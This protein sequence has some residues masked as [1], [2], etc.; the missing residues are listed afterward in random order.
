MDNEKIERLRERMLQCA[1]CMDEYRDPRILPCHHTLCFD[2]VFNVVNSS[3][4][5][6][7]LFKC[8]QCRSDVFVPP[9]GIGDLPINFYI[10]SLQDELG[11]KGYTAPCFICDRDWL[12]AQF[13][14]MDCDIDICRFCIHAH[15]LKTHRDIPKIIRI[16]TSPSNTQQASIIMCDDHADELMQMFCTKCSKSICITCSVSTHKHH[17]I[18]PLNTKLKE[19]KSFLQMQVDT[20]TLEKR[21]AVKTAECL[22]TAKNEALITFNRSRLALDAVHNKACE[23]IRKKRFE[24]EMELRDSKDKQV[25]CIDKAL[26]DFTVYTKEID[27]GLAFL[28]DL[29][30]EDMC[31][32]VLDSYKE[33]SHQLDAVRRDVTSNHVRVDQSKFSPKRTSQIFDFNFGVFRSLYHFGNLG[34]LYTREFCLSV[35][36]KTLELSKHH[37]GLS[38]I[39]SS[40]PVRYF[41]QFMLSFLFW[42]FIFFLCD[43]TGIFNLVAGV[44]LAISTFSWE[45]VYV[46]V[47]HIQNLF[48]I[49]SSYF[50]NSVTTS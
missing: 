28:L 19:S 22:K 50:L 21:K 11:A 37:Q 15:R 45:F 31:L 41:I 2:C 6:G 18:I 27:R 13:R 7:R 35:H 4:A 39:I 49:C 12:A 14:C 30:D 44:I 25:K 47:Q 17:T 16:E 29:L 40:R 43:F 10:T 38:Y 42:Q 9:G 1:V 48:K 5:S 24:I 46:H 34:Y 32:E 3:S 33:F 36:P 20:L 26:N 23:M 8:P